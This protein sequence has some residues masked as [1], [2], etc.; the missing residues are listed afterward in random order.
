[1]LW[2]FPRR[3]PQGPRLPIQPRRRAMAKETD[4]T[5]DSAKPMSKTAIY[6]DLATRTGLERK[7]VASV[8]EALEELIKEQLGKKGPGVFALSDLLKIKLVKKPARKA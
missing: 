1:M 5:D 4:K 8:L 3:N 6:Q 7:D 2:Y